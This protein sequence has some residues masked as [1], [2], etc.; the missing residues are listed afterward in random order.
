[1]DLKMK[2]RIGFGFEKPKSVHLWQPV[3]V[4]VNGLY[5]RDEDWTE[6]G[7]IANFVEFGL[8]PDSKILQNLGSGSDFDFS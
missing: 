1:M 8:D 7:T 6:S 3:K 5:T 4:N 2:F